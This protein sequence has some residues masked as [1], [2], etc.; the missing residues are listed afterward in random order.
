MSY[1]DYREDFYHIFLAGILVRAGYSVESNREHGEGRSD[2]IVQDY[3]G[4]RMAI[5]QINS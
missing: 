3:S 5:L 4:D 1:Y 2:I